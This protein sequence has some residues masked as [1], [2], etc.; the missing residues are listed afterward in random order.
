M[1]P[2]GAYVIGDASALSAAVA[3]DLRA[4]T[5]DGT[6]VRLWAP[7]NIIAANRP[8]ELAGRVAEQMAP[9]PGA[10]PEAVIANP[11]RPESAAAAALAAALRLP[12]LFADD[13]STMPAP[14]ATA[15]SSLGVK[16]A[17]I[18]GSTVAARPASARRG[19]GCRVR[20]V[21]RSDR[22]WTE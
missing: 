9:L 3:D 19:A 4:T 14:T 2:Q 13:R 15:I 10:T 22:V 8:A 20:G 16:K 1:K 11:A 21:C 5:R 6:V 18:V 7:L 12:I 17:I